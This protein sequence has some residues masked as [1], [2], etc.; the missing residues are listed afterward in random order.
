MQVDLADEPTAP[1]PMDSTWPTGSFSFHL[2]RPEHHAAAGGLAAVA[3]EHGAA[4]FTRAELAGRPLRVT[5]DGDCFADLPKHGTLQACLCCNRC[6]ACSVRRASLRCVLWHAAAC[7][8]EPLKV[9]GWRF[10]GMQPSL[11]LHIL[12]PA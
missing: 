5:A 12:R 1:V 10:H 6:H 4:A 11:C 8:Q 2:S 7:Q 3:R 9:K